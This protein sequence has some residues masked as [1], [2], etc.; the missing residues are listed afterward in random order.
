MTSRCGCG[1]LGHPT[2]RLIALASARQAA[3]YHAARRVVREVPRC[4]GIGRT[5]SGSCAMP[6]CCPGRTRASHRATVQT[7]LTRY[8]TFELPEQAPP[9]STR[10]PGWHA[11]SL[12][13]RCNPR[14]RV[15]SLIGPALPP[16]APVPDRGPGARTRPRPDGTGAFVA[17]WR[18][19]VLGPHDIGN[20]WSRRARAVTT[21]ME[22][23]Q[24]RAASRPGPRPLEYRGGGFESHL[25]ALPKHGVIGLR[26]RTTRR[27]LL[28]ICCLRRAIQGRSS[29]DRAADLGWR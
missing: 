16:T 14:D 22:E 27:R 24:A 20:R 15:A 7:S 25:T 2:G 21:G 8:V 28:P 19:S 11:A 29:P 26:G 17:Q 1:G 12:S 5:L 18:W 13:T 3:R 23:P 4:Q 10:S 6:G 9:C